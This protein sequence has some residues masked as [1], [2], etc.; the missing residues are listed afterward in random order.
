MP[1]S[2]PFKKA[3]AV[4]VAGIMTAHILVPAID[5]E[6]PG[7]LSPAIVTGLL[8]QKLGFQG[9]VFT[10]DRDESDQRAIFHGG[11]DVRALPP[12]ATCG[13]DVRRLAGAAIRGAG[14]RHP[15][16]RRR[17]A[18][19]VADRGCAGAPSPRRS[20]SSRRRNRARWTA[21]PSARFSDAT[22]TRPSRRKWRV[23]RPDLKPRA[24]RRRPRRHRGPRQRLCPR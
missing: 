24:P 15:R 20:A 18:A 12:A 6:R 2:V 14:G 1:W 13:P 9:M 7:T 22:N 5:E 19:A 3:I 4:G 23:L 8:K 16:R 17:H 21:G 10:D 11:G